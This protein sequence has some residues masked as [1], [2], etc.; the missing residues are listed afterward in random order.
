MDRG[1][2]PSSAVPPPVALTVAFSISNIGAGT[3]KVCPRGPHTVRTDYYLPDNVAVTDAGIGHGPRDVFKVLRLDAKGDEG[4][5]IAVMADG[6]MAI[7]H[8]VGTKCRIVANG[9]V[10]ADGAERTDIAIVTDFRV[11]VDFGG[12][13]NVSGNTTRG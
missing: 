11:G 8:D 1:T 3:T 9:H 2:T 6:G 13:V 12:F 5:Y 7:D 10:G 4:K